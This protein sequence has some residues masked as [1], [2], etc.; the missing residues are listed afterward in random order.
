MLLLS[1]GSW[2]A[3][4]EIINVLIIVDFDFYG[5][6]SIV[7]VSCFVIVICCSCGMYYCQTVTFGWA[8]C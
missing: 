7:Y 4:A 5:V 2:F 3:I 8:C 6:N 1:I